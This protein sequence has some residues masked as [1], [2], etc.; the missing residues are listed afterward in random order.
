MS[1]RPRGDSDGDGEL[2]SN[3]SVTTARGSRVSRRAGVRPLAPE[4][5]T[6]DT[7][8]PLGTGPFVSAF[9]GVLRA[10]GGGGGGGGGVPCVASAFHFVRDPALWDAVFGRSPAQWA[11]FVLGLHAEL[12]AMASLRHPRAATLLGVQWWPLRGVPPPPPAAGPLLYAPLY[13][14]CEAAEC[15]LAE[16]LA[17]ARSGA[18]PLSAA[19]A[20]QL[21]LDASE[22]LAVVHRRGRV[23]GCVRAQGMFVG[24]E[25]G[26]ERLKIGD[27]G[28]S[29][30][31]TTLD[32][33]GGGG[34]AAAPLEAAGG[35]VEASAAGDVADLGR[36]LLEVLA[37]VSPRLRDVEGVLHACTARD[38]QERPT[39][40][41]LLGELSAALVRLARVSV[42]G[43][44]CVWG[45]GGCVA[46]M[47][48][49]A[50]SHAQS[51]VLFGASGDEASDC[52]A[53]GAPK[54]P[55]LCAGGA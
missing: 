23:H 54:A 42:R 6:V 14:V 18:A 39:A 25:G 10:R 1:R 4:E 29:R 38:A 36:V 20:A 40:A 31:L 48:V 21:V 17:R 3:A 53:S 46:C 2:A 19:G 24:A 43:C 41:A 55:L 37:A 9:R 47:H 52:D 26:R 49:R 34:A 27:L 8:A 51:D 5:L 44:V 13:I 12:R 15:T 50:L 22:A 33:P 32:E 45:G 30:V 11:E 35:A 28:L 7:G 16:R